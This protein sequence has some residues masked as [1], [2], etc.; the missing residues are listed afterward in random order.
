MNRALARYWHTASGLEPGQIVAR[1]VRPLVRA[2][3]LGWA[4]REMDR[5]A[6]GAEPWW[7]WRP[8]A[9]PRPKLDGLPKETRSALAPLSKSLSDG[10]FEFA[11]VRS[12]AGPGHG[13]DPAGRTLLW[14]YHLNYLD[15]VLAAAV[16]SRDGDRAVSTSEWD[17][18]GAKVLDRWIDECPPGCTPGWEPYPLSMR[19][20]N[21][22]H[23]LRV[24]SSGRE[25]PARPPER[26]LAS[27]AVQ[28]GCLARMVEHD[29]GGNH[30]VA[31]GRAL[32]LAGSLLGVRE[33][34]DQGR[35]LVL[36]AASRQVLQDGGHEERSPSYHALVALAMVEGLALAR[37]AGDA[38]GA[39][40]LSPVVSKMARFLAD[41]TH[42]DGGLALFNDCAAGAFPGSRDLWNTAAAWLDEP[43][44]GCPPASLAG[45]DGF[46]SALLCNPQH[47]DTESTED[48]RRGKEPAKAFEAATEPSSL[49]SS[50]L[51]SS[52]PRAPSSSSRPAPA[53]CLPG[54]NA[55]GGV[56]ATAGWRA[57]SYPETGYHGVAGEGVY[58]VWDWGPV[59]PA[60][61]PAHA[62]ADVGSFELSLWGRRVVV[63]SGVGTYEA[64]PLRDLYRSWRSHNVAVADGLEPAE[65]WGAFR[66]ARKP[67]VE[68]AHIERGPDR[69]AMSGR[70]R[71][72]QPEGVT[73]CRTVEVHPGQGLTVADELEGPGAR[74]LASA[75]HLAPGVTLAEAG[76]TAPLASHQRLCPCGQVRREQVLEATLAGGRLLLSWH[77][78]GEGRVLELGAEVTWGMEETYAPRM[79]PPLS[80]PVVRVELEP[81]TP[82]ELTLVASW[83]ISDLG[84]QTS[85]LRSEV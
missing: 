69:F 14:R 42:P 84:P 59:G 21:V 82:I 45:R 23:A 52:D 33:W 72:C 62:H 10:Q 44:P 1:L 40:L 85:D 75:L 12:A 38:E 22:L 24:V 81:H 37:T 36:Q 63:D 54:E 61:L 34:K 76:D 18:T 41:M 83:C 25:E 15:G 28:A 32:W 56:K 80:R 13:W 64:S 16:L 8:E 43:P 53:P 5:R 60:H 79:G 46:W 3:A 35:G 30:V 50:S 17:A 51:S 7:S 47:G 20:V 29:I 78:S 27:V 67:W 39:R 49:L 70:W 57:F 65:F 4:R 9:L 68:E 55:G 58:L 73:L 66:V 11:G 71:P 74:S 31:N 26:V 6:A 2:R 48:V 77:D 19:L